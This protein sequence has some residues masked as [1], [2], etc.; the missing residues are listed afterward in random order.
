MSRCFS[1]LMKVLVTKNRVIKS[2]DMKSGWHGIILIFL[3]AFFLV[4]CVK[5]YYR[6]LGNGRFGYSDRL[7][8]SPFTGAHIVFYTLNK[9]PYKTCIDLAWYR[10]AEIGLEQRWNWVGERLIAEDVIMSPP[11]DACAIRVA[12]SNDSDE[13]ESPIYVKALHDSLKIVLKDYIP[14][15]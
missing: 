15:P 10:A 5:I 11:R 6:E 1:W 12:F 13:L 8:S 3:G 9:L 7:F 2:A 4:S 14:I